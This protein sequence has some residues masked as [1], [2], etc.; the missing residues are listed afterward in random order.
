MTNA[1]TLLFVSYFIAVVQF[2]FSLKEEFGNLQNGK[3]ERKE[4]LD[5]KML[6]KKKD[7]LKGSMTVCKSS[8]HFRDRN[9]CP[10]QLSR[11][12]KKNKKKH[13]CHHTLIHTILKRNVARASLAE[14]CH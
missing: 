7:L 2:D 12:R 3:N 4:N 14:R 10:Q 8:H 1:R 6:K 9:K 5:E 13:A 11:K